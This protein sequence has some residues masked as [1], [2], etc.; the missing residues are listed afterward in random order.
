MEEK[1]NY[2]FFGTLTYQNSMIP[3]LTTSQGKTFNYVDWTDFQK[4]W[5]RIRKQNPVS[6]PL[7][8]FAVSEYGGKRHRPHIHFI[9]SVPK[10]VSDPDYLY[11]DF[12]HILFDCIKREWRR[13]VGSTRMPIYKPLFRYIVYF[14][15]GQRRC[16]YDFH[17]IEPFFTDSGVAGVTT[18]V[19]KYLTKS[20]DYVNRLQQALKINLEPEEY[21]EVWNKL[22][23]RYLQS[24]GVGSPDSSDVINYV[25]ECLER[26]IRNDARFSFYN[27]VDGKS[28]PLSRYYRGK[29]ITVDDAMRVYFK[30]DSSIATVDSIADGTLKSPYDVAKAESRFKRIQQQIQN[31]NKDA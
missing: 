27:T 3:K 25:R 17:Y 2:L 23:P 18:Y 30:Q 13:N 1:I 28:L 14:V 6:R 7:K 4:M 16:T 26:S 19:T 10:Y 11:L 15:A 9:L 20:D 5:K 8:Y 22:R 12:E 31:K 21:E 29:F 24:H